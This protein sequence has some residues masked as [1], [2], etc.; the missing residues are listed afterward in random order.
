MEEMLTP[1]GSTAALCG[2]RGRDIVIL[3]SL[4]TDRDAFQVVASQLITQFRVTLINLPGFHRSARI[5]G[6]V[7]AY[8]T[9]LGKA[10]DGFGIGRNCILCGNGFGGT[11]ALAFALSNQQRIGKLLLVDV[12]PGFPEQGKAAFRLMAEKATNEGM[13][14]IAPIAAGRVYHSAYVEKNPAVI[15]ERRRV[16]AEIDPGAFAAACEALINC[17]LEPRLGSLEVP[18][19]IVYGALDQ[20]TPPALN[21]IIGKNVHRSQMIE[22]PNCGHCPPLEKPAEFL[23]PIRPFIS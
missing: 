16:L 23:E 21:G 8:E 13:S 10:L 1:D 17:N 11:V 18:T 14:S 5:P 12:A 3:H 19:L 4:L 20:A 6:S 2:G 22:I 7:L 15:E 9:W